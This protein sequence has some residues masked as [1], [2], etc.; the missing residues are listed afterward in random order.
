MTW[1]EPSMKIAP[2]PGRQE[3]RRLDESIQRLVFSKQVDLVFRLT[4]LTMVTALMS[5][6][7]MGLGLYFAKPGLHL[8]IMVHRLLS[9]EFEQFR[10]DRVLQKIQACP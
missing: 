7:A 2:M 1:S 4:P 10:G 9:R 8:Y 6:V 3:A 5:L